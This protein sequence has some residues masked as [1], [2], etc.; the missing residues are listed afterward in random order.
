MPTTTTA[1]EVVT[2]KVRQGNGSVTLLSTS[3]SRVDY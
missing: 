2:L 1:P 3:A